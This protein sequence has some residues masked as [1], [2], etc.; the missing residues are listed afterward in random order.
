[1]RGV[2]SSCEASYIDHACFLY[3]HTHTHTHTHTQTHTETH[4]H[5]HTH[6]AKNL[7]KC[8]TPKYQ[9]YKFLQV[10][11]ST[12]PCSAQK[13]IPMEILGISQYLKMD[14]PA[15]ITR[16]TLYFLSFPPGGRHGISHSSPSNLPP[17][18]AGVF[19]WQ[20]PDLALLFLLTLKKF[21]LLTF[22]WFTMLG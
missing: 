6:T 19:A 3:T 8:Q 20:C 22:S 5:T 21:I 13:R 4:T 15:L 18:W 14:F 9:S 16:S 1:M 7:P 10:L 12:Q 11:F 17:R 2:V